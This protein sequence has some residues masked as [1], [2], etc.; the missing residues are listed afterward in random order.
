MGVNNENY[1]LKTITW[2]IFLQTFLTLL[3]G[4]VNVFM[5]SHFSDKAVGAV[6]VSNQIIA[7]LAVLYN[8]VAMGTAILITQYL[9]AENRSMAKKVS[10]VSLL[11]NLLFGLICSLIFIVFGQQLLNLIK[12]PPDMME[13]GLIYVRIVGGTSFVQATIVTA[14]AIL[15][16]YGFT[17]LPMKVAIL[18]NIINIT[19]NYIALYKPFGI[20]VYG[21]TGVAISVVVSNIVGFIVIAY[22]MNNAINFKFNLKIISE[23]STKIVMM[24]I[25][26]GAPSAGEYISYSFSQ[27]AITAVITTFGADVIN[28]GIFVKNIVSFV[29]ILSLSVGQGTQ[30]II[31]YMKGAGKNDLIYQR[32]LESLKIAMISNL[33]MSI[34][35][36]LFSRNILSIFT[37]N[38]SIIEMGRMIL[39]IDIILEFGRAINHVVMSCLRGTGDVGYPV[40]ISIISMWIVGVLLSHVLGI[41]FC[42]GLVGV[43]IASGL[44]EWVRGVTLFFRWKSKKWKKISVM[45]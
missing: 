40:I 2:P 14:S 10:Q 9:G 24:V 30:I 35:I 42:L 25:K 20:P 23:F 16:S 18:M 26:V 33:I 7:M 32:G 15:R 39:L 17:K 13:Y 19:G 31:G 4:N 37:E 22:V 8:V 6:G 1:N 28:T 29:Y 5:L 43:W 34:I 36:Y 21:V 45:E 3:M 41:N 27:I 44:D 38:S 11:M 12:L